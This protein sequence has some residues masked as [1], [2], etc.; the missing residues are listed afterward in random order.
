MTDAKHFHTEE[1]LKDGTEAVIRS[2]RADDKH[3]F[4]DAFRELE[5]ET[6]YKRF[7]YRK[8]TLTD[9]DLKAATEVDFDSVVALVVT[10]NKGDEEIIIGG[11]RYLRLNQSPGT[12][13]MAEVAFTVEE[14]YHGQGIATRLLRHLAT[15]AREKGIAAFVAEVLPG[16]QAM[17]KVFEHSGLPIKKTADTNAVHVTLS[18]G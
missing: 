3:R 4:V 1:T 8:E 5:P 14:D 18:L 12:P 6:I 11:G 17:I 10:L 7:F 16:N 9:Q 13:P 2:V 15:I